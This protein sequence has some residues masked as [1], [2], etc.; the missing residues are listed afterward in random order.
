MPPETVLEA[1]EQ[2]LE[3]LHKQTYPQRIKML[4][5]TLRQHI[6]HHYGFKQSQLRDNLEDC[7]AQVPLQ[8]F[9]K[10]APQLIEV[11]RAAKVQN[12]LSDATFR[13]YY[14][15]LRSFF[16][17]IHQQ[18][19]YPA[20][21]P[22]QQAKYAPQ[23]SI[24]KTLTQAQKGR[25][26]LNT[27]PYS[28]KEE[29]L[30]TKVKEH[31][32][33]LH[34]F[35]TGERVSERKENPIRE[36]TFNSYKKHI[37]SFLG[38]CHRIQGHSLDKVG[39]T[40]ISDIEK[41]KD[42]IDWGIKERKNSYG[43][44]INI[45]QSMIV[46][47]KWQHRHRANSD[48]SDV[49][50]VLELLEYTKSLRHK[51][52]QEI[53][54]KKESV[55]Q[56]NLTSI[57][58]QKII[59]YLRQCCAERGSS[60]TRRSEIAILRSWQHYMIVALMVCFPLRSKEIQELELS[61]SLFRQSD[62]SWTVLNTAQYK[63]GSQPENRQYKITGQ[64]AEDLD[65]W[66]SIW[67]PKVPTTHKLVFIRLGSNRTPESLGEP[68]TDRDIW[69][70][71]ER[72]VYRATAAVLGNPKRINPHMF[73]H[74]FAASNIATYDTNPPIDQPKFGSD[75]AHIMNS[76]SSINDWLLK[77]SLIKNESEDSGQTKQQFSA[78]KAIEKE[79]QLNRNKKI[80]GLND[81]LEV[82]QLQELR[83]TAKINLNPEDSHSLEK[84]LQAI[85]EIF[86]KNTP[87]D[88]LT[89]LEDTQQ[90][91]QTYLF[92][93]MKLAIGR[94]LSSKQR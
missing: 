57:E 65:T 10:D 50:Q 9:L 70:L 86:Y 51:Y 69:E 16:E 18:A 36:Q 7:L 34:A 8:I 76:S 52:Q 89:D 48:W 41:I 24:G 27:Y 83:S 53:S 84:Y 71:V 91:I 26:Q 43:W 13:N 80:K 38:W 73:R 63:M 77:K 19:W 74:I 56:A 32:E 93:E 20:L 29:K 49:N 72:A 2:Y 6:L 45:A 60:G 17:W 3:V 12:N 1:Y 15:V 94:V 58:C 30:P 75:L 67:R 46:V 81:P 55:E 61:K 14:S 37:L 40:E 92:K 54:Q 87:E 62:N 33:Q 4:R 22:S 64:L 82:S 5:A 68:L 21:V 79:Q 42:F 88:K 47:A 39:L 28:L 31:L 25:R 66:I 59:E 78:S 90:A 44:A 85:A 23:L 35:W 11:L